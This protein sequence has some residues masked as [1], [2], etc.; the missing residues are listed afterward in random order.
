MHLKRILLANCALLS[1]TS[2]DVLL[3]SVF[4]SKRDRNIREDSH[5]LDQGKP[6]E[7]YN[8]ERRL[9]LD[10]EDRMFDDLNNH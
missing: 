1:L 4:E 2:C 6:L 8:S 10:Q 7:H 3:D 5:N 9:K